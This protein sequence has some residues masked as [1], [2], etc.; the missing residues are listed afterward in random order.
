MRRNII[1]GIVAAVVVLGVILFRR[2][3]S[4]AKGKEAVKTTQEGNTKNESNA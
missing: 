2:S 3:R 1:I 4:A